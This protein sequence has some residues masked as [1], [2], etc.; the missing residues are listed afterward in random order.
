MGKAR[1]KI[2]PFGE[3]TIPTLVIKQVEYF[4][5]SDLGIEAGC[6]LYLDGYLCAVKKADEVSAAE[7]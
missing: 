4:S 1:A 2:Q 7:N 5:D 3:V 6:K